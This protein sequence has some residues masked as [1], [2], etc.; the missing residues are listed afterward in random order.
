MAKPALYV[1]GEALDM[2]TLPSITVERHNPL[3]S[4]GQQ[5]YSYPFTI[6]RTPRNERLLGFPARYQ[7]THRAERRFPCTLLCGHVQRI[8]TLILNNITSDSYDCSMIYDTAQLLGDIGKKKLNELKWPNPKFGT[9]ENLAQMIRD[10]YHGNFGT[11]GNFLRNTATFK[12]LLDFMWLK[13]AGFVESALNTFTTF[14]YANNDKKL[15]ENYPFGVA[16]FLRVDYVLRFIFENTLNFRL[17]LGSRAY[18]PLE[19]ICMLH[20]CADVVV[21]G[22]L[23]VRQLLADCTVEDFVRSV[24]NMF[25]SKFIFDVKTNTVRWTLWNDYL[26]DNRDPNPAPWM[27]RP[28]VANGGGAKPYNVELRPYLE[29]NP[30]ASLLPLRAIKLTML[31]NAPRIEEYYSNVTTPEEFYSEAIEKEYIPY[32]V[33]YNTP[34]KVEVVRDGLLANIGDQKKYFESA[35]TFNCFVAANG[36]EAVDMPIEAEHL[37]ISYEPSDVAIKFPL[38]AFGVSF[39]NSIPGNSE[40]KKIEDKRAK[41]PLAFACFGYKTTDDGVICIGSTV[42]ETMFGIQS[43]RLHSKEG[44]FN[45]YH[46]L[47]DAVIRSGVYRLTVK[48][49]RTIAINENELYLFDGQPVMVESVREDLGSDAPQTVALQ[50]IKIFE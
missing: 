22:T 24:E 7:R 46:F 39:F 48:L 38:Y 19:H 5:S 20:N 44:L 2:G 37:A 18:N 36:E 33:G 31:R 6:P 30:E 43:L 49:D 23:R 28:N 26:P 34:N 35:N 21:D 15:T 9:K 29:G 25:C 8:G 1:N 10:S 50:T 45:N 4:E 16:P 14:E 41:R 40:D 27:P 3:L 13:D 17:D 42:G 32:F 47:R 11:E 12:V